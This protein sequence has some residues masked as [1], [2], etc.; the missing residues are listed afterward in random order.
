MEDNSL[1]ARSTPSLGD[2]SH[3]SPERPQGRKRKRVS[4]AC[5]ACRVRK[6]RCNGDQPCSSCE[7]MET[8]CQYEQP[9]TRRVTVPD[10]GTSDPLEANAVLERRLQIIEQKLH[11]LDSANNDI[12]PEV[13]PAIPSAVPGKEPRQSAIGLKTAA[14]PDDGVDGMGAVPLKDGAD[15]DEYFGSSSN[16][17]FLHF[18]INSIGHPVNPAATPSPSMMGGPADMEQSSDEGFDAFLRTPTDLT[19]PSDGW[20]G[21][22]LI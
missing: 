4:V 11:V 13:R 21:S 15:E 17:A 1:H 2:S 9:S 18:I 8:Q 10:N 16:V 5:R 20:R 22:R 3:I 14:D 7:D 19:I 6:S 12:S